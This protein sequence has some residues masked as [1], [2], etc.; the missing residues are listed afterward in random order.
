MSKK[1][2]E[3]VETVAAVAA[4]AKVAK[5]ATSFTPHTPMINLSVCAATCARVLQP[6]PVEGKNRILT[7]WIRGPNGEQYFGNREIF[8]PGFKSQQ[9]IYKFGD[10]IFILNFVEPGY[11]SFTILSVYCDDN[12]II[13]ALNNKWPIPTDN[14][15][16][17]QNVVYQE[18]AKNVLESA[19]CN[20]TCSTDNEP[21]RIRQNALINE[22]TS[23]KNKY[24]FF[25]Q[26]DATVGPIRNIDQII[27]KRGTIIATNINPF[28]LIEPSPPPGGGKKKQRKTKTKK[29]RKSTKKRRKSTKKQRKTK[30]KSKR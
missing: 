7:R 8:L 10:C 3:S 9:F 20:I 19:K 23:K 1:R 5:V 27:N 28:F 25:L 14:D 17:S 6:T 12:V 4:V 26:S 29:R 18:L 15:N 22:A 13:N 30:T 24:S 11:P 2:K 16:Y 21:E